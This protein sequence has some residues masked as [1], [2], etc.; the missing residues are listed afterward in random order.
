MVSVTSNYGPRQA[1]NILQRRRQLESGHDS[2]GCNAMSGVRARGLGKVQ[3]Y[4]GWVVGALALMCV[5]MVV[6]QSAGRVRDVGNIGAGIASNSSSAYAERVRNCMQRNFQAYWQRCP[7][8]DE[9]EPVED[10]C[11][12]WFGMGLTAIDSIDTLV[13]MGLKNEY[14]E[15]R[16]WAATSMN[17]VDNSRSIN[18]FELVIRALGGLNSAYALT[19][20]QLWLTRAVQLGDA[21]LHAFS[22]RTGCPPTSVS[23]NAGP[24]AREAEEGTM[25]STAEA[26]TLQ[27]EFR[28]LTR[29]S[30]DVRYANAADKCEAAMVRAIPQGRVVP[31]LFDSSSGYY[32]SG[33]RQTIGAHVDSFVEM[34]L[35]TWIAFGKTDADLRLAFERQVEDVFINLVADANGTIVL[36]V[37][38]SS[39]AH[40][41]APSHTMEHL[42]C[43]FPGALA[44]AALHGLGG[45]AQATSAH[46]YMMRARRLTRTCFQMARSNSHGLP[47]EIV[48][49]GE[50]GK[51]ETM[52]EAA[53]SLLRPEVVE[54][55]YYMHSITGDTVYREWGKVLWDN[56]ER[57]ATLLDGRLV[58]SF[59]LDS[60][61]LSHRGKLHSF[62]LAET[63]K[64][65]FLL[66]RDHDD[67]PHIDLTEW[68]FNTEAHP[69]HVAALNHSAPQLLT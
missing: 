20:D 42:A 58:N 22:S 49:L 59:R 51:L 45:G 67:G 33:T 48:Q 64:Y 65:F 12:E 36:G 47:P 60:E 19:R 18:M 63:L 9:Y 35:K 50:D 16:S 41:A 2:G 24:A 43:F 40:H 29:M 8:G 66:F 31:L 69:V 11:S 6:K 4:I 10:S 5:V 53:H 68:V 1:A 56:I 32:A 14:E 54:S 46:D 38:D 3:R 13:L 27:L 23:L 34:L 15:V 61:K 39:G 7:G 26:G 17:V 52:P 21:V 25:V 37:S 62:V 57:S 30:G 44:L 55:L 28:T